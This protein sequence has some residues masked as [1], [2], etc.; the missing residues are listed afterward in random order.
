MFF[1][2]YEWDCGNDSVERYLENDSFRKGAAHGGRKGNKK[3]A[4]RA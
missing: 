4:V 3:K 2:M 1:G